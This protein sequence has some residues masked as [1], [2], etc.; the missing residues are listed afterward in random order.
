[1]AASSHLPMADYRSRDNCLL[2]IVMTLSA[3]H[4]FSTKTKFNMPSVLFNCD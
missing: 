4:R 2:T 1:M 3:G